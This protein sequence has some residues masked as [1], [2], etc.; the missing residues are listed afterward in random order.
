MLTIQEFI[1]KFGI[2]EL[3]NI[4]EDDL[5]YGSDKQIYIKN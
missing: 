5:F 2:D 1:N 4:V 3:Q